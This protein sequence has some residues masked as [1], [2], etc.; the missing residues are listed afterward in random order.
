MIRRMGVTQR[1]GISE[2]GVASGQR[3]E[4]S[5]QYK[6]ETGGT[7]CQVPPARCRSPA[8]PRRSMQL[9]DA[10]PFRVRL[11]FVDL[12]PV[13]EVGNRQRGLVDELRDD[14]HVR[15]FEVMRFIGDLMIIR[16][17]TG[18]DERDRDA[19]LRVFVVIA[20]AVDVLWMGVRVHRI[21]ESK[22]E[23]LLLVD[24]LE[25]VTHLG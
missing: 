16:V 19:E 22:S 24:R 7:G 1:L 10:T 9:L 18:R 2:E 17:A 4:T 25:Q 23:L 14:R 15:V 5:D 12:Q 13:I 11:W 3:T 8:R 6:N 20:S 21:I